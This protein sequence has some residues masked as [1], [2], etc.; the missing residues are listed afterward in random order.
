MNWN[1][2]S[3][4]YSLLQR[5]VNVLKK[6]FIPSST[7]ISSTTTT[8][9]TTKRKFHSSEPSSSTTLS[10]PSPANKKQK[11]N[12]VEFQTLIP[13]YEEIHKLYTS[14][15]LSKYQVIDPNLLKRATTTPKSKGSTFQGQNSKGGEEDMGETVV[16]TE[17]PIET[18]EAGTN[19]VNANTSAVVPATDL[20]ESPTLAVTECQLYIQKGDI[21]EIVTSLLKISKFKYN[22]EIQ[23]G[24][25]KLKDFDLLQIF[26]KVFIEGHT[27][28]Y[29]TGLNIIK[30]T[31]Y[32]K[33]QK[34]NDIPSIQLISICD[35]IGKY[36]KKLLI[37]GILSPL[38][39]EDQFEKFQSQLIIKIFKEIK[40]SVEE[41]CSLLKDFST[42][43]YQA[44]SMNQG[45]SENITKT[46]LNENHLTI[47]QTIVNQKITLN[48]DIL[49]EIINVYNLFNI[50]DI[51]TSK[52]HGMF[53]F[54][55]CRNCSKIKISNENYQE[56]LRLSDL[57]ETF[58]KKKIKD[59]LK[60]FKL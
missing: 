28:P 35:I 37:H 52:T 25:D 36:N 17:E 11:I 4:N 54:S 45:L 1:G 60:K 48:N 19:I 59:T 13:S 15:V 8:I 29:N 41:Y 33:L 2:H 23:L 14:L 26:Q 32:S 21:P 9:P 53:L 3:S 20:D 5:Q 40:F 51:K 34:L 47:I 38:L 16:K 30:Y 56:L 58:L 46:C 31:L 57:N 55:L 22:N 43:K 12:N 18:V 49:K 7:T 27:V 44:M 10:P 24:I 6:S 50:S 39:T 42:E